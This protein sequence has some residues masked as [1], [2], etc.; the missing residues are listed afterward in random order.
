MFKFFVLFVGL[1]CNQLPYSPAFASDKLVE[2]AADLSNTLPSSC[3]LVYCSCLLSD[4]R[5]TC[6]R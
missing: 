5:Q 4:Q 6:V 1:I 3:S 2:I